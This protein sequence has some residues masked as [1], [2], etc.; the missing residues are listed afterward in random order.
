MII[1]GDGVVLDLYFDPWRNIVTGNLGQP[2]AELPSKEDCSDHPWLKSTGQATTGPQARLY[3]K[4][5]S[6]F[7]GSSHT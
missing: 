7:S 2:Q 6:D 4:K 5:I 3:R 1:F